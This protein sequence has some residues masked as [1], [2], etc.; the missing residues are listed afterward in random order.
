MQ[1]SVLVCW[2]KP[3]T[4]ACHCSTA[5][6]WPAALE[7]AKDVVKRERAVVR[8]RERLNLLDQLNLDLQFGVAVNLAHMYAANQLYREALTA[9]TQI[10]KGKTHAQVGR[11]LHTCLCA[12]GTLRQ[13]VA[14]AEGQ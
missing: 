5:Y 3:A 14:I 11:V 7:R 6:H 8:L 10:V 4:Q 1:S 9:Y 13:K 12:G 2:T